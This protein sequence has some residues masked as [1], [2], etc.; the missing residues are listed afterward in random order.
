MYIRL[1]DISRLPSQEH[2]FTFHAKRLTTKNKNKKLNY[3]TFK[4]RLWHVFVLYDNSN[5]S[6]FT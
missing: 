5:C 2:N 4:R 6:Y 3:F 1:A